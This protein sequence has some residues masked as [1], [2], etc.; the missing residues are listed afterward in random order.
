VHGPPTSFVLRVSVA[1]K[2]EARTLR[3]LMAG[4]VG[5]DSSDEDNDWVAQPATLSSVSPLYQLR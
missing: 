1:G 3:A 2:S 4:L 5:Y